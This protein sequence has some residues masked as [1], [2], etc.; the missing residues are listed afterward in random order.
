MADLKIDLMTAMFWCFPAMMRL[1]PGGTV[2]PV[3]RPAWDI[4]ML[5]TVS[6]P[7]WIRRIWALMRGVVRVTK[8]TS[9]GAM[10]THH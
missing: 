1:V 2:L 4:M 9:L 10:E 6:A 8:I 7:V 5:L 3:A